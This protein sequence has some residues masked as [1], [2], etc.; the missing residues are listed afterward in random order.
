MNFHRLLLVAL[1]GG[2]VGDPIGSQD[3]CPPVA[4]M[5]AKA[6]P[7]RFSNQSVAYAQTRL[8][9]DQRVQCVG[10]NDS[11]RLFCSLILALHLV[12]SMA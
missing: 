11:A 5:N 2:H 6:L 7:A 4:A 9:R 1:F 8:E 3:E 12:D 10:I